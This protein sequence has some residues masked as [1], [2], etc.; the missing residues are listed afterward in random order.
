MLEGLISAVAIGPN[1]D[2]DAQCCALH[3]QTCRHLIL[4]LPFLLVWN[5]QPGLQTLYNAQGK[6]G[7]LILDPK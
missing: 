5:P 1:R 7:T 3:T 2:L 4:H 6:L